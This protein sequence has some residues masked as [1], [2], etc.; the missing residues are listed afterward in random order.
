MGATAR[1]DYGL[2]A[3]VALAGSDGSMKSDEI[4]EVQ[5]LPPRFLEQ[6]LAELRRAGLVH[7]KRGGSGGYWLTRPPE[8]IS[9]GDVL[10]AL[11][12][13]SLTTS[14][15]SPMAGVWTQLGIAVL[16]AADAVR[17]TDLVTQLDGSD[18]AAAG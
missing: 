2:R 9:V 5:S 14:H 6:V 16:D 13:D 11:D 12:G 10:R 7:S 1:L 17:L 15:T 8:E 3:L 4:A 18:L